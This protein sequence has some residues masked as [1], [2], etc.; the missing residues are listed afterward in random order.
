MEQQRGL[1]DSTDC[2]EAGRAT[3]PAQHWFSSLEKRVTLR[4]R[5]PPTPF[6]PRLHL[7][8]SWLA[9]RG[10]PPVRPE[11]QLGHNDKW[12]SNADWRIQRIA[13]MR[14]GRRNPAQ[15]WF[16]SLEK[17]ITLRPRARGLLVSIRRRVQSWRRHCVLHDRQPLFDEALR[18]GHHLDHDLTGRLDAVD[19]LG[20]LAARGPAHLLEVAGR[21]RS[22]NGRAEFWHGVRRLGR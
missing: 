7:S 17:R 5:H 6:N 20:R 15:H 14:A 8:S 1:A 12:I 13:R 4:P 11:R 3:N 2:A 16:S 21:F 10:L 19:R 22:R 9:F 18:I